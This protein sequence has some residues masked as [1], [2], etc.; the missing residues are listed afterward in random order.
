MGQVPLRGLT[1]GRCQSALG[2]GRGQVN[3]EKMRRAQPSGLGGRMSH[4]K[5]GA[6]T[7]E[8]GGHTI[9]HLDD[10]PSP[11]GLLSTGHPTCLPQDILG[12]FHARMMSS[13]IKRAIP[14]AGKMNSEKETVQHNREREPLCKGQGQAHALFIPSGKGWAANSFLWLL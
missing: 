7:A 2:C 12:Y 5:P 8:E 3:A 6:G 11:V 10:V 1:S 14:M 13:S 9:S 4:P